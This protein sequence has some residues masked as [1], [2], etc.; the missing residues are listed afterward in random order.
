MT[1]LLLIPHDDEAEALYWLDKAR[2]VLS[3]NPAERNA[4]FAQTRT[5]QTLTALPGTADEERDWAA[6]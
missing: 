2:R 6:M 3:P 1:N 5:L 4:A